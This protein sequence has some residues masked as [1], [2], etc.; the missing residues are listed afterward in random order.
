MKNPLIM[1]MEPGEEETMKA[2]TSSSAK[3][4][5]T[6]EEKVQEDLQG[7]VDRVT[8]KLQGGLEKMGVKINR[9]Q[10]GTTTAAEQEVKIKQNKN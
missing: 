7:T 6:C 10:R 5:A 2:M 4:A 1:N 8:K 3:M 9:T